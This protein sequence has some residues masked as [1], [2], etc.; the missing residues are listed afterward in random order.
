LEL[1]ATCDLTSVV[2]Y[3]RRSKIV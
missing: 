1:V 3:H 2:L